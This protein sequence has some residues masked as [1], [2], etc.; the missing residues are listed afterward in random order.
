MEKKDARIIDAEYTVISVEPI[1]KF[2][3]INEETVKN[4]RPII[5]S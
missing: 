4:L 3:E 1:T 2:S 5:P